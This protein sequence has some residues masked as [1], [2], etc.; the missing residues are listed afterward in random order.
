MILQDDYQEVLQMRREF[1]A[2]RAELTRTV[3]DYYARKYSP[4]QPRVPAGRREGGQW[5][6]DGWR[7]LVVSKFREQHECRRRFYSVCA[8]G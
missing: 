7:R 2:L 8:I 3:R 6:V 4:N 1:A 5:P